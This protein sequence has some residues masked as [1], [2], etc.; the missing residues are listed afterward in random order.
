MK[1]KILLLVAIMAVLA[2]ALA[3]SVS[4]NADPNADYYDKVYTD[5][6]GK[7]FPIYEKEGDTYYSLVWFAY[8]IT[9]TNE[10]T[11][12]TTV[13]ETKY[14]KARLSDISC[15][16]ENVGQGRF[17]GCFYDYV[18]ED[19]NT[20]ELNTK[21]LI[22]ANLRDG[23]MTKTYNGSKKA[24]GTN[25]TICKIETNRTDLY[26]AFSK[27]EA[28]YIPHTQSTLGGLGLSTLRVCD[29][30]KNHPVPIEFSLKALQNSKIKEIFIPAGSTFSQNSH[31][32][33][34]TQL[35]KIVF[36]NGFNASIP[37]YFFDRCSSLKM[38]C[39]LGTQ[40]EL[41]GITIGTVS[42]GY[43]TGMTRI[44]YADYTALAD[45]S[46]KYIIYDCSPCLA[47]N[48]D[49]HTPSDSLTVVEK[50]YFAEMEVV[51]PCGVEG[52][53]ATMVAEKISALFVS[54]G[55][56]YSEVADANGCFSVTQG[57]YVNIDAV[58]AYAKICN[59]LAFGVV[60]A[61][62]ND[63]PLSVV[64]GEV[65]A[66]ENVITASISS[67][68]DGKIAVKHSYF[69]IKV[70]GIPGPETEKDLTDEPIIFNAYVVDNGEI[71][72]LHA[73]AVSSAPV[74]V[75]YNGVVASK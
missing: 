53:S 41:E 40:S 18:D 42:N 71:A 54:K 14:V 11:G 47:Y 22:V 70:V 56:S 35:E 60:A 63:S 45:K 34:C 5:A 23:I 27:L 20:V 17:N 25:V 44:S 43:F 62:K 51:C 15:Y 33:G 66:D 31:F 6:S 46:G 1:K 68:V 72:Y 67:Y 21:N 74:G 29:I 58:N 55:F 28:V 12:E 9:E 10:E 8:D 75:S 3:I 48:G 61:A 65:V 39:F 64:D 32:Q 57:F 52:C 30:D 69:D 26:P 36:G 49:V 13:V 7:N 19:G 38:V 2:C 50:N 16:C 37:N 59:D 73:G 4:A 24:N